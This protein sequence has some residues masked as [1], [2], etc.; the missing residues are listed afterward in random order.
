MLIYITENVVCLTKNVEEEEAQIMCL[1][2]DDCH[3]VVVT[4]VGGVGL[5]FSVFLGNLCL[6]EVGLV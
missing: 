3:D 5:Y 6:A 1:T 2:Q 4:V